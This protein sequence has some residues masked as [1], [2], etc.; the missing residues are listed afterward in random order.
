MT[1]K[2]D[3][4]AITT[5]APGETQEKVAEALGAGRTADRLRD[6]PGDSVS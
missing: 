4:G 3:V 5:E 6:V 2:C 1:D